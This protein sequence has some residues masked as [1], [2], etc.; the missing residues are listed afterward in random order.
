[1]DAEERAVYYYLKSWRPKA[2]PVRDIARRAG[3]R[4]RFRYNPDWVR[5]VLA[6][7]EERGIVETDATGDYR[8]R[9]MPQDV[10]VGKRW[11]S[12]EIAAILQSSGKG[13]SNVVT[14]EVEDAYYEAL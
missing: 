12:P 13:F 1:M 3:S 10:T 4:R 6:R 8:L 9:P 11:A 2:A 5:P 7:M 14:P